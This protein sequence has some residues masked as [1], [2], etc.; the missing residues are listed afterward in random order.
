MLVQA[1]SRDPHEQ[2]LN[3]PFTGKEPFYGSL[4]VKLQKLCV[5]LLSPKTLAMGSHSQGPS[6]HLALIFTSLK[7]LKE[8]S[9]EL[10]IL[11]NGFV[12]Q[13]GAEAGWS[14]ILRKW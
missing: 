12:S 1:E 14:L 8:K 11:M 2:A 9:E 7:E 5:P 6:R 10:E 13:F 3:G 4:M